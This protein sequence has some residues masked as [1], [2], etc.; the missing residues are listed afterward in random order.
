MAAFAD[1]GLKQIALETYLEGYQALPQHGYRDEVVEWL[2]GKY[3]FD[4][5][6]LTD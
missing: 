6:C 5:A 4:P 3:E 2:S 1:D